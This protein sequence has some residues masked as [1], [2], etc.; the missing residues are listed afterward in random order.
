[1]QTPLKL[2]LTGMHCDACVRR[3]TTALQTVPGVE[4]NSVEVGS[5]QLAFDPT[6][7]T[8]AEIVAAVDRIGFKAQV[9]K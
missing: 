3:V 1:M 7:S 5:A 2:T 8:T 4:V 6:Q 9:E